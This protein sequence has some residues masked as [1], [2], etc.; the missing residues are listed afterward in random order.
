MD[1]KIQKEII[2]KAKEFLEKEG[3][4]KP[5][6][7]M[8]LEGQKKLEILIFADFP[9]G[10]KKFTLMNKTGQEMAKIKM[11]I[12]GITFVAES[13]ISDNL[14][15]APSKDPFRSEAIVFTTSY[16]ENSAMSCLM[17]FPFKKENDRVIWLTKNDM[18][19]SKLKDFIGMDGKNMDIQSPLLDTFWRGYFTGLYQ[20][21][22]LK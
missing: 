14:E 21:S 18:I 13:W 16:K 22:G 1:K 8:E 19:D 20:E 4:L 15:T 11:R 3:Y 6:L 5:T 2:N 9:E 12:K 10:E 7:F 17:M